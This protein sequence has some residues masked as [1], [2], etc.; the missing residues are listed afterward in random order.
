MNL[1]EIQINSLRRASLFY[2]T[3]KPIEVAVESEYEFYL[4][5]KGI[6][7]IRAFYRPSQESERVDD[8]EIPMEFQFQSEPDQY[9]DE[10]PFQDFNYGP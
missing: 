3:S 6:D 7:W 4:R 1:L 8:R 2:Q 9:P 5:T 10:Y